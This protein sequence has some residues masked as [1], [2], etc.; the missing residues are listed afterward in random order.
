MAFW[1]GI[2]P[3]PFFRIIEKPVNQIVAKVQPGFFSRPIEQ[4]SQ[5]KALPIAEK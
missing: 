2:Y 5:V 4:A 3:K 1:I